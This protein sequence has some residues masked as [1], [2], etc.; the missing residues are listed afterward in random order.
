MTIEVGDTG[1]EAL[2]TQN[3]YTIAEDNW[4]SAMYLTLIYTTRIE[5]K[6]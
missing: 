1:T 3:K 5:R 6:K 2:K 4:L